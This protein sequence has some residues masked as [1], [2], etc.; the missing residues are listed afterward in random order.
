MT[1]RTRRRRTSTLAGNYVLLIIL[2][3]IFI[4]PFVVLVSSSLKP[5]TQ[6]VFSFPPDFIPRPPVVDWFIRAWTVID[7]PR[8]LL[9]SVIY[10]GVMVPAYLAVSALTAYPLA[11]MRFRLRTVVFFLFLSTMFLPGELM[12]IPR[13]LVVSELGLADSYAGVM[14]PGILS[15]IGIFLLRQTFAGVPQELDDAARIDGCKEWGV[16]W[17]VMLPAAKPAFAVLAIFGFISVWNSFIWPLVVLKDTSKYPI[18]LGIAYLT[19]VTGT[20][21]RSLAAGTVI[22]LIPVLVFFL[23]MQ[24]HILEG[25]KGAVK[26]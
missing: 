23:V 8:Y 21:V 10:V 3:I 26:G 7:F 20:D 1:A 12:L 2:A 18:A 24:R 19:G 14:L 25:M 17:H 16:F 9:N 13:F 5:A 22:S 6:D 4:G 15:A 11:R